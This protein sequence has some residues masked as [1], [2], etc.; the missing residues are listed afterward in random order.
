MCEQRV[1]GKRIVAEHERRVVGAWNAT[2]EGGLLEGRDESTEQEWG[3]EREHVWASRAPQ[4]K[5]Q[6]T[7][8]R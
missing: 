7:A 3:R 2:M 5:E 6:C 1:G 4:W 8:L